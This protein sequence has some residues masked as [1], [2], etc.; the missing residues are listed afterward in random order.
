MGFPPTTPCFGT[1]KTTSIQLIV[2]RLWIPNT[3]PLRAVHDGTP[4]SIT[5]PSL[6]TVQGLM[7]GWRVEGEVQGSN[8]PQTQS[9]SKGLFSLQSSSSLAQ[10]PIRPTR[11]EQNRICH[12]VRITTSKAVSS[13]CIWEWI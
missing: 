8:P 4:E 5:T 6:L 3:V 1:V 13:T 2:L 9:Q 10:N 12:S 11:G 7:Q